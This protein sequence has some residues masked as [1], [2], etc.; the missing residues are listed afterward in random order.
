MCHHVLVFGFLPTRS[1]AL[2]SG[3]PAAA[4]AVGGGYGYPKWPPRATH[5]AEVRQAEVRRK[6]NQLV[7]GF[8]E[9]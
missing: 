2:S 5:H 4:Q 6:S 1:I 7:G 3:H 9:T 8:N